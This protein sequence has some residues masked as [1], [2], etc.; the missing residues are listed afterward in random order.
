MEI[1]QI[2]LAVNNKVSEI[3]VGWINQSSLEVNETKQVHTRQFSVKKRL[4]HLLSG[5][6]FGNQ[7]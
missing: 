7:V 1:A 4:N 6:T 2:D 5:S 3:A